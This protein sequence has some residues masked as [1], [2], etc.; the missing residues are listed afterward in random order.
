FVQPFIRL[1]LG[2]AKAFDRKRRVTIRAVLSRNL[3]SKQGR[4]DYV[5]ARLEHGEQGGLPRAVPV[6]GRSGLLR[7]MLQAEGLIRIPEE[8]EGL[9][10][11]TELDFWLMGH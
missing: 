7:T 6:L 1:L 8:S 3:P 5:R 10:Q 4:E 11:D 2:D 9:Y